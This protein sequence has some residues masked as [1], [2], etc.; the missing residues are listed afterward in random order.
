METIFIQIAAYR[1]RELIPTVQDAIAQATHPER[2]SFGICWQYQTEEELNSINLLRQIN[3][4]RIKAI[5]ATQSRGAG[6]AR[7][8]TQKLW[9][10]ERYTLQIDS[11]M[12]LATGWDT[13]LIE[14]L[15]Q[16][17]SDKAI[18]SAYPPA[19]EPPRNLLGNTPSR[20]VANRFNE[21][22][23]LGLVATDDLSNY[24]SP[25][26]GA[27]IAAGF[28]FSDALIIKEVPY[29]PNIYF[30][31]EEVLFSARAWTRGWDIF[32]PHRVVC[33]HY[34]HSN[35]KRSVHWADHQDW[36]THNQVSEQRFRQ[37]TGSEF[38]S[39]KFKVYGLGTTRTLAEYEALTGIHFQQRR[40]D[41]DLELL[42]LGVRT[43]IDSPTADRIRTL[44]K[45]DIDWTSLI[46]T[47]YHHGLLPLLYHNLNTIC[48]EAVPSA[49]FVT[50]LKL[51]VLIPT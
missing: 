8:K 47:A 22:G 7:A 38:S 6:W 36:W 50:L 16:C 20:L 13:Q 2:L 5:P 39:K 31:G 35:G 46:D 10:G 15:A 3:N 48:P 44:L 49:T 29:D 26:P 51:F 32:H 14:M 37:I 33:W 17:P 34:Y 11:H 30:L 27:F 28:V 21:S 12:R 19:Y 9:Q 1:D 18:L 45:E 24:S 4:C 42:Q 43:Q 23:I 25:Q 40:K 41:N